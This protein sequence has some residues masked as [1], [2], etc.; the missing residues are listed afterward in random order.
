MGDCDMV[1][2]WPDGQMATFIWN[3]SHV[4]LLRSNRCKIA[5]LRDQDDQREAWEQTFQNQTTPFASAR[6][7]SLSTLLSS[8]LR[9]FASSPR[10]HSMSPGQRLQTQELVLQQ[11]AIVQN[12][13]WAMPAAGLHSTPAPSRHI[14]MEP[15]LRCTPRPLSHCTRI[16]S[17]RLLPLLNVMHAII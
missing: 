3:L 8:S 1:C 11:A 13:K 17:S 2:K 9:V 12:C 10:S 7:S 16:A 5:H 14:P 6:G 4:T 15:S